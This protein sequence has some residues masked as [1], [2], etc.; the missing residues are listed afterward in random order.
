V[1]TEDV[2][3]RSINIPVIILSVLVITGFGASVWLYVNNV[4]LQYQITTLQYNKVSLQN[5]I[6]TLQSDK[7]NLEDQINSLQDQ[8][9]GLQS[10]INTLQI[11]YDSL[12]QSYDDLDR[13]YAIEKALRIGNSLES[14]YDYLRQEIGPTGVKYWWNYLRTSYWQTE[15]DFAAN[16][17]LHDLRLIY[18]P[19]IESDYY[20]DIG[21]Y[22]YDTANSKLSQIVNLIGIT[23]SDTTTTKI[24]KILTFVCYYIHYETEVNDVFLA[25]VE[26]LGYKSGDCDDF[27]IL[28]AAIFEYVGI[29]SAIGFF[30]NDYDEYHAMVLINCDD[31][32]DYD[33]YY[34]SN[35]VDM[36]LKSGR[37]IVI[38][39]QATIEQQYSD[40]I[41]QWNLFVAAPLDA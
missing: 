21:E 41:K 5:Q 17:A 36:G 22:S 40:W 37:W 1:S 28:V 25:P 10:Q 4:N 26:T 23:R 20:K 16:L 3:K 12:S 15:V 14:Y 34:F 9:S 38:E 29:D 33:Y 30:V 8:I 6:S 27:T 18:W 24:Q 32:K 31:L 39:P 11:S 19:S 2:T 35:L 13:A 7:L